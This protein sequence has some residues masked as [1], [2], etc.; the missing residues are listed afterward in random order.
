MLLFWL[1]AHIDFCHFV[2]ILSN[3][4]QVFSQWHWSAAWPY[5][6]SSASCHWPFLARHQVPASKALSIDQLEH[7]LEP[8][9][10]IP[11]LLHFSPKPDCSHVEPLILTLHAVSVLLPLVPWDF[12]ASSSAQPRWKC[13]SP[14]YWLPSLFW[15]WLGSCFW[16]KWHFAWELGAHCVWSHWWTGLSSHPQP[17]GL[18]HQGRLWSSKASRACWWLAVS[19]LDYI[20]LFMGPTRCASWSRHFWGSLCLLGKGLR[21]SHG[22]WAGCS[23]RLS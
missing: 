22:G 7:G 4:H 16:R 1:F 23:I 8:Q 6:F 11:L 19:R 3:S 17:V 9:S 15:R 20:V 2:E 10:H 18:L 12:S 14:H 5:P 21:R 13:R